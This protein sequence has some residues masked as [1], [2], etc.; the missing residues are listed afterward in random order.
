M[1]GFEKKC[2]LVRLRLWLKL[3]EIKR[4]KKKQTIVPL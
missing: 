3:T 4:W 1:L 2:G